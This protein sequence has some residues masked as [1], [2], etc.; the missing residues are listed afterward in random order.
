RLP[1]AAADDPARPAG[2][3]AGG[4]GGLPQ[5]VPAPDPRG[6]VA[7]RAR[8]RRPSGG[9][10]GRVPSPPARRPV[11][12]RPGA[13]HEQPWRGAVRGT[14]RP[15]R[16]RQ[17]GPALLRL[18]PGRRRRRDPLTSRPLAAPAMT[19]ADPFADLL[20]AAREAEPTV[21]L[22]LGSGMGG[23]V[24]RTRILRSVP[25]AQVPGLTASG[26]VGHRGRLTLAEWLG[27]SLLICEGRLH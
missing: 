13:Q 15:G 25:Y 17:G 16:P 7:A 5:P 21:A 12:L 2:G 23:I 20:V 6:G 4:P 22:V 26:V 9:V 24:D 18:G 8:P 3:P 19:D 10:P 1:A 11:R 27:R 14:D